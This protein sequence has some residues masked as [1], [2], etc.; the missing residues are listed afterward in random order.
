[1]PLRGAAIVALAAALA[2]AGC[3]KKDDQAAEAPQPVRVMPVKSEPLAR[4]ASYVGTVRARYESDLGFRVAGK[5]TERLVNVGD[6]VKPG[7]P[8]AR[9][10]VT[11]LQLTREANEA[12]LAAAKSNLAQALAAERR[13]KDLLDRGHVSAAVYDQR[14]AA[15]DE[16]QGRMDRAER[17]LAISRNQTDYATLKADHAGVVTA[18]PVEVGQVVAAGQ[19]VARVA[20]DGE[21][22]AVVAIPEARLADIRETQPDV[23]LWAD[24][25]RRYSA[26]LRE[27][28]PQ[29]DTATRTYLAR[30]TIENPDA[31]VVLGMTATVIANAGTRAEVVRVP[32]TAVI[33]DGRGA[34]VWVVQASGTRVERRPVEI[35]SFGQQDVLVTRGLNAGERLVTL[36]VHVLDEARPI[37]VVE[38][39][40]PVKVAA[41]QAPIV[42]K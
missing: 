21:R 34:S 22:E 14:K 39:R 2:L 5:I 41:D 42:A 6:S 27:I 38:E 35:L 40:P 24:A 31:A 29:A 23:V 26:R 15:L 19:L 37:K 30:F 13:G 1:M 7:D 28:S 32:S 16:A 20:Q 33:N 18:L 3:Q 12:E 17:N 25:S 4:A 36:G 9:L 8:L 11:D 10:D